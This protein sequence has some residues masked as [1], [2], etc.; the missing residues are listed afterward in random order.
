[1]AK[2]VAVL[3]QVLFEKWEESQKT[4]D[5]EGTSIH[6]AIPD[7]MRMGSGNGQATGAVDSCP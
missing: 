1:M 4:T 5:S 3:A 6:H 2:L 7:A